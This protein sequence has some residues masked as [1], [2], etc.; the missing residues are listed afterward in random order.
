MLK[1]ININTF[2]EELKSSDYPA[3][4]KKLIAEY[5]K[6]STEIDKV[7]NNNQEDSYYFRDFQN[8]FDY[9][10]S[11]TSRT[12]VTDFTQLKEYILHYNLFLGSLKNYNQMLERIDKEGYPKLFA[13]YKEKIISL[14]KEMLDYKH[15]EYD[16]SISFPDLLA[17]IIAYYNIYSDLLA[18]LE[19]VC[20]HHTIYVESDYYSDGKFYKL[21]DAEQLLELDSVY[22]FLTNP[23]DNYKNNANF[24]EDIELAPNETYADVEDRETDKLVELFKEMLEFINA[25]YDKDKKG[26]TY[27]KGLICQYYPFY[28]ESLINLS[29]TLS[30]PKCGHIECID[31]LRCMYKY[32]SRY[33]EDYEQNLAEYN[34]KLAHPE[35]YEFALNGLEDFDDMFYE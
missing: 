25:P 30:D 11:W 17:K 31:S 19:G 8:C 29:T 13:E 5:T 1:E 23:E 3:I 33:K 14:F 28:F 4:Q 12:Y 6:L 15:K 32:L 7:C 2:E 26:F 21:T 20:D 18:D 24:Y 35:E 34:Y 10:K 16:E 27:Y 22:R 9:V